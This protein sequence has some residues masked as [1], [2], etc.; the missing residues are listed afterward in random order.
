MCSYRERIPYVRCYAG[1]KAKTYDM[2]RSPEELLQDP[3]LQLNGENYI[4]K[5]ILPKLEF[6]LRL[7]GVGKNFILTISGLFDSLTS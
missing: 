7:I 3:S 4:T 1:P 5:M 2:P 6:Y